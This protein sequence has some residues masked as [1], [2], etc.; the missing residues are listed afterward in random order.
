MPLNPSQQMLDFSH[1]NIQHNN[2]VI[3]TI[4]QGMA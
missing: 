3:I 4:A 2:N 1:I